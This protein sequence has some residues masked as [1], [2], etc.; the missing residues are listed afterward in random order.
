MDRGLAASQSHARH[1]PRRPRARPYFHDVKQL[2]SAPRRRAGKGGRHLAA[3]LFRSVRVSFFDPLEAQTRAHAAG[4][5]SLRR[6]EQ[7]EASGSDQDDSDCDS[8]DGNEAGFASRA[9]LGAVED[10]AAAYYAR[11]QQTGT[12]VIPLRVRP[13]FILFTVLVLIILAFLG[14]HPNAHRWTLAND[15]ILHFGCFFVVR[16]SPAVTFDMAL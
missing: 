13:A 4:R 8:S 7:G 1:V 14:F 3:L 16:H 10:E 2:L 11:A 9:Y 5:V 12:T 15:K 6:A